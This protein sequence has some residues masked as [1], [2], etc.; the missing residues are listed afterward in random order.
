MKE[1]E[2][3]MFDFGNYNEC[4]ICQDRIAMPE[5]GIRVDRISC[6]TCNKNFKTLAKDS[7]LLCPICGFEI[8][9]S[10]ESVPGEVLHCLVCASKFILLQE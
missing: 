2:E 5:K 9:C 1:E 4:G 10:R 8:E 6:P 7:K 3:K